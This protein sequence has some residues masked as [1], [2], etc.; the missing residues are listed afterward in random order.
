MIKIAEEMTGRTMDL[1]VTIENRT[2]LDVVAN[3]GATT[4]RRFQF[5]VL[6]LH[7]SYRNGELSKIAWIPV[8]NNPADCFTKPV[9]KTTCFLFKM[10]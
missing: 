2:G 1:A 9:M 10:M 3:D 4:E 6:S 5:D 7:Q 8:S